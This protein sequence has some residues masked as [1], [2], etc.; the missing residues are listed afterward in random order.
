MRIPTFG[1]LLALSCGCDAG[2]RSN[3]A[4]RHGPPEAG[5][6]SE[7]GLGR[8]RPSIAAAAT[9][10]AGGEDASAPPAVPPREER[11]TRPLSQPSSPCSDELV[12]LYEEGAALTYRSG[13][14]S[15][16]ADC[17]S[18]KLPDGLMTEYER[19]RNRPGFQRPNGHLFRAPPLDIMW[20]E[21]IAM[22]KSATTRDYI[23]RV[24]EFRERCE[25]KPYV[26]MPYELRLVCSDARICAFRPV[27]PKGLQPRSK[28]SDIPGPGRPLTDSDVEFE[29]ILR[30]EAEK[31]YR[32]K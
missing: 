16:A 7:G 6:T 23:R 2:D 21:P 22:R 30:R 14:C 13:E 5:P 19:T 17:T 27:A 24:A 15:T 29:R 12:A 28:E 25:R 4:Q 18:V 10:G 32:S 20:H 9:A 8:S 1:L 31:N 11:I 26:A 3:S